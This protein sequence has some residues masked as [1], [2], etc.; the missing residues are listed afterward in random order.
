[1]T[2]PSQGGFLP[3][4]ETLNK[5]RDPEFNESYAREMYD[6][7]SKMDPDSAEMFTYLVTAEVLH[8]D[9]QK[10]LR[11]L[12][13]HLD[14]V[15]DKRVGVVSKAIARVE[16]RDEAEVREEVYKAVVNPY[17]SG[18]YDFNEFDFK[19][20]PRTG[21]FMTKLNVNAKSRPLRESDALARGIAPKEGI[22][23]PAKAQY[24]Q[25]YAQIAQFLD[26]FAMSGND[27]TDGDVIMHV[28]NKRSGRVDR[29]KAKPGTKVDT[30]AWN[31]NTEKVVAVEARP[32]TLN[33]GGMGF[34]I[35]AGVGA[36]P[37]QAMAV[38]REVNFLDQNFQAFSN[39]WTTQQN[40]DI[41][42]NERLYRR[43][44]VAGQIL[45]ASPN[46]PS[47]V[48]TAG[49]FAELVGQHGPEAEK[50]IGPT[51]RKTAYRYRGTE[52]R[53]D[54]AL[55]NQYG[56]AISRSQ[57]SGNFDAERRGMIRAEQTRA[58]TSWQKEQAKTLSSR[59]GGEIAG[60]KVP[61][62]E[63]DHRA[64]RVPADVHARLLAEVEAKY[65]QAK[66][67]PLRTPT[68][69]ERDAGRAVVV[70]YLRGAHGTAF[71]GKGKIPN[72]ALYG[73][74]LASG[75]TP[76]SQGVMMNAQGQIVS[77]AVGYG[78]DHYLPFNLRNLKDLKGGE[79]V[80]T[81]S[82]GGPTSE[83]IYTGLL[84]GARRVTVV[85]RSGVFSVE[86]DETFRGGR[87]YNDKAM[88]MTDR[89][90]HILDAVQSEQVDS[91][92][93]K[94]EIRAQIEREAL[95][96][97]GPYAR[98]ADVKA[99]AMEKIEEYKS[100]D[101]LDE[102][103]NAWIDAQVAREEKINPRN[104]KRVRSELTK[105]LLMEKEYKFRLNGMG[106]M[107]ALKALEEQFPYY[108]KVDATPLQEIDA[109]PE[110]DKGY[111]MPRHNR[112]AEA[113]AG[114]FNPRIAG[115]NEKLGN[116][117]TKSGKV[118][119]KIP[120]SE[121]NYQNYRFQGNKPEDAEAETTSTA[122]ST[123]RSAPTSGQK[124]ISTA[125][126]IR[127]RN[128][129]SLA[130]TEFK[131]A[132]WKAYNEIPSWATDTPNKY[133]RLVNSGNEQAFKDLLGTPEARKEVYTA[134]I[135]QSG[136]WTTGSGISARNEAVR[137]GSRIDHAPFKTSNALVIENRPYSFPGENGYSIATPVTE[138]DDEIEKLT[139]G[140][141]ERKATPL[142]A[143]KGYHEMDA[144]ELTTEVNAMKRLLEVGQE[145]RTDIPINSPERDQAY[146]DL[147]IIDK[148]EAERL[149]GD[150]DPKAAIQAKAETMHRLRWLGMV[151][152][153]TSSTGGTSAGGQQGG[154]PADDGTIT[155]KNDPTDPSGDAIDQEAFQMFDEE[156]AK[157]PLPNNSTPAA[158]PKAPT[159]AK[160]K[161]AAAPPNEEKVKQEAREGTARAKAAHEAKIAQAA[162]EKEE[163]DQ[164][165]AGQARDAAAL[166]T[167]E[168][169][170]QGALEV[171]REEVQ[172]RVDQ[173][174][175][176]LATI[177]NG[178]K[179]KPQE[180]QAMRNVVREGNDLLRTYASG[181]H[182]DPEAKKS[183]GE[184]VERI[185]Y[186]E[187]A[188][189][190]KPKRVEKSLISKHL[191]PLPKV[192]F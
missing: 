6:V 26:T 155:P 106:Y 61:A 166:R 177:G 4:K 190:A 141:N 145:I 83:D 38:G 179:F 105:T 39:D 86:F 153:N 85:S 1:M 58:L 167:P 111:V 96:E 69:E 147:H 82:V 81:R 142:T 103:D 178:G 138:V 123:S 47:S 32:T 171:K 18:A 192:H 128:T 59:G 93:V 79:Y 51:A 94:P 67:G 120:A 110:K 101:G 133:G 53:P 37:R 95:E 108:I 132:A 104:A 107:A 148:N 78:D 20:D 17:T 159:A 11:T 63:A 49:R 175:A 137:L 77:E 14:R 154:D 187:K 126:K 28:Q 164:I 12:Q 89:Y 115:A 124:Q 72:K 92:A 68:W 13:G 127:E 117:K 174:E 97:A 168:A 25:E 66:R 40:G 184:R 64:I 31:P 52:K 74:N 134:M 19:R 98:K 76:P 170:D 30:E 73:L 62:F 136:M 60:Q 34:N 7:V 149:T 152:G 23:A 151:K 50:V 80:R 57:T 143:N 112:P 116:Q 121:A 131:D 88:R 44:K 9:I 46:A 119:G 42:T 135:A 144:K 43:T 8:R 87:R 181:K 188:A 91:N 27:P 176:K 189:K 160:P 65:P 130:I 122:R 35:A 55:V 146:R 186:P 157:N 15:I 99:L 118:A 163:W 161:P 22:S 3:I 10:N 48:K 173:I 185:L 139:T 70:D 36:D 158:P 169:E 2:Q 129:A 16:D 172:G 33:A 90:E 54:R 41:G 165:V 5:S 156:N 140:I 29:V 162:K 182:P 113:L 75:N 183:W 180:A 109:D 125:R 84:T 102:R 114:Y 100:Y 24:Q 150:R 56:A 71:E 21:R 191:R 45:S